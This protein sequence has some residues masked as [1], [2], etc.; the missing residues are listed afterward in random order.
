VGVRPFHL[1]GSY[2]VLELTNRCNLRCRHCARSDLAHTHYREVGD[3]SAEGVRAL[4]QD[5]GEVGARFDN[6]VLFWL[7]EPLCHPGFSEVYETIVSW[8]GVEALFGQVEVHSNGTLLNRR[9]AAALVNRY[10][11]PQRWHF[12]VDAVEGET[13]ARIKGRPLLAR[14]EENIERL[15]R[16][17][18]RGGFPRP[19]VVVQ[20]IVSDRNEAEAATFLSHWQAMFGRYGLGARAHAYHV[21]WGYEGD[22]VFFRSLDC[23][24]AEEQRRQDRVYR[25][26]VSRL[27][28]L[29]EAPGRGDGEPVLNRR[30]EGV[31]Q[32]CSGFWKSPVIGW[33]G[34]LTTCTRDS[35][36][37]NLLG[38]VFETPFSVLWFGDGRI[39]RWRRQ[40][41]DG[42]YGAL[43]LCRSCF[44]P[45]SHNYTGITLEEIASARGAPD[46]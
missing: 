21:P 41:A 31:R 23:P 37:D 34:S 19:A 8:P 36:F 9:V 33:E 12:S 44:I 28:L 43:P 14:V 17:R 18:T 42:D 11:I 7:G 27:G 32:P 38:N 25:R 45:A 10:R 40:V 5:L 15:V 24:T 2:L 20:F 4:L 3:F 13:Y 16:F 26:V 30:M 22:A 6:L 46:G 39:A 35:R 1:A 29:S